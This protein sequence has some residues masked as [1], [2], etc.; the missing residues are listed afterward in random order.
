MH[1]FFR[2][3]VLFLLRID[4]TDTIMHGEMNKDVC[5]YSDLLSLGSI[6]VYIS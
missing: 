3:S 6:L 2:N 4:R 5:V 1:E